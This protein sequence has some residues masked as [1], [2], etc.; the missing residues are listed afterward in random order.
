MGRPLILPQMPAGS[1]LLAIALL[2][3]GGV[4]LQVMAGQALLGWLLILAGSL[5]GVVRSVRSKRPAQSSATQWVEVLP[6]QWERALEKSKSSSRAAG[7][8]GIWIILIAVVAVPVTIFATEFLSEDDWDLALLVVGDALALLAPTLIFGWISIWQPPGLAVQL[9][10]LLGVYREL[11]EAGDG[12][13]ILM[14]MLEVAASAESEERSVPQEARMMIR[15]RGAPE[16]FI[17]VQVQVSLNDVS[18]TK[19]PYLYCVLLAREGLAAQLRAARVSDNQLVTEPSRE[20]DVS[21][22]VL[23]QHTTKTSGYHT[24]ERRQLQI[25]NAALAAA[26]QVAA[27]T[28]A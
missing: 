8:Q 1:R 25:V 13:L 27:P 20:G 18:G 4:A 10:A 26:R 3:G 6:E 9:K 21:V 16:D 22:L 28:A 15:L 19:Y 7:A 24:N 2:I 23:R 5:L 14:P 12:D 17:G 11:E